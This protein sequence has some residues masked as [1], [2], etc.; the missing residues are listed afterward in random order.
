M[1]ASFDDD[2]DDKN[3]TDNEDEEHKTHKITAHVAKSNCLLHV[4]NET[5]LTQYLSSVY[6]VTT[7]LHISGLLAAHHQEVA[8]Y[9]SD[10]W[11]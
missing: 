2:D 11:P 10:N 8:I 5:N 1:D 9:V 3:N 7:P 6:S 4:C